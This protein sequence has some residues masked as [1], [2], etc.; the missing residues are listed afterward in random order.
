VAVTPN[1]KKI[2]RKLAADLIWLLVDS[3]EFFEQLSLS[4]KCGEFL[5]QLR[6][7]RL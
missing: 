3:F 2:K 1:E 6:N 7:C 5:Q 4:I